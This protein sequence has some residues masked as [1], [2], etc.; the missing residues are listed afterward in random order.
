MIYGT[1]IMIVL[2]LVSGKEFTIDYSILYIVSLGWLVI[3]ASIVAFWTYLTL[4]SRVGVDRGAYATLFYP[5][6]ALGLSTIFENYEWTNLAIVGFIFI[7]AGNLII[8]R[9]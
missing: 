2:A 6:V 4:I 8:I 7:F 1:L 9:R 5:L 3:F